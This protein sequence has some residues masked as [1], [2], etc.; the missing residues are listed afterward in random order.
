MSDKTKHT[1]LQKGKIHRMRDREKGD[2]VYSIGFESER[3]ESPR[4]IVPKND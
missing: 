3:R 4:V 2:T 1:K